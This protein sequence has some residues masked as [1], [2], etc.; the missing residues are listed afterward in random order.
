MAMTFKQYVKRARVPDNALGDFITD[1]RSD[2]NLPNVKSWDQLENYL[3]FRGGSVAIEPARKAWRNYQAI[4]R[5]S[6]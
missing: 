6:T 5:R 4:Q 3:I 2:S 1:A